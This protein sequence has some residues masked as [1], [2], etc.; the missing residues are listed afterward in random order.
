MKEFNGKIVFIPGGSSGI[1][2]SAAKLLASEGAHV[3]IFARNNKRLE[4]AAA[5]IGQSRENS[6]QRVGFLPLD[7]SDNAAVKKTMARAVSDF[8]APD[9][10]I[11]CAGRAYP[12]Y[13]ANISYEQ[14][15]ETMRINMY[16]IWNTCSALV[17]CMKEHGGVIVNTSSMVG[18]IGVFGY[19]DYSASKFAIVGFSETLKSELK[20][21][22]IRV[23]VLCPPDTDTPGFAEE[24]KTKPEET[25]AISASAK[26]MSP[27]DVA[28]VL[29]RN[30]RTGTFMIIPNLDGKFTYII[31]RLFPRLAEFVMDMSIRKVQKGRGR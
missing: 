29:L 12:R 17:P 1:G 27:D 8:G 26:L 22:D 5:V 6:T 9:L 11:N 16:G 13:F 25:K 2:L 14:F 31:K 28:R 20:R 18:F 3:M 21:Y 23:Q 7:V 15:D 4:E 30:I 24:N 19:T 10:L